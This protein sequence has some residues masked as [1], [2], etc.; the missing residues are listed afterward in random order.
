GDSFE[1][2]R[3]WAR[4]KPYSPTALQ[5]TSGSTFNEIIRRYAVST[6]QFQRPHGFW[7]KKEVYPIEA[8]E[9]SP[10]HKD[11][12]DG[13]RPVDPRVVQAAPLGCDSTP[14]GDAVQDISI[15]DAE[16]DICNEDTVQDISNEDAVEDISNEDAVYD[17]DNEDTVYDI[18][19]DAVEDISNENAVY[20]IANENAVYDI[21]NEDAVQDISN[22]DAVEDISNENAVYDIAN[23]DA[24]YDIAK[25]DAVQDLF[26]LE[27]DLFLES[28]SNDE[29]LFVA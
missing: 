18:A 21:A 20:D 6:T 14:C 16:Y 29:G 13:E 7:V 1:P 25:E 24:V 26:V 23:E 10:T 22:E 3:K 15:E 5:V 11:R 19:N 9:E 2:S 12:G 8:S 4:R 27:N 17:I 28:I